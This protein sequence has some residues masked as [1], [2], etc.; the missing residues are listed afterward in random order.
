MRMNLPPLLWVRVLEAAVRHGSFVGAARELCVCPGAVSRTI[1]EL[2]AFLG[3]KLFVR[4]ARGVV[5]TE[6]ARTYAQAI[7]PALEQIAQASADVRRSRAAAGASKLARSDGSS[8]AA[9][10]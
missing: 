6:T 1:K 5:P 7:A 10:R 4:R 3:A 9:A 2:E 8:T